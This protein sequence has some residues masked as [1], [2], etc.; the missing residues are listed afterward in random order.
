[1]AAGPLPSFDDLAVGFPAVV[2][3]PVGGYPTDHVANAHR[4]LSQRYQTLRRHA[5]RGPD[6]L[7]RLP[8]R[9]SH[10]PGAVRVR[11]DHRLAP[12]GR[13]R[14]SRCRRYLHR[15]PARQRPAA[16]PARR[17]HRLPELCPVSSHER[18]RK[19]RLRPQDERALPAGHRRAGRRGPF[20]ISSTWIPPCWTSPTTRTMPT[21]CP[22]SGAPPPSGSTPP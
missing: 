9:I 10:P 11:Q 13:F 20:H 7:R 16:Q 3:A 15:R 14:R 19:R 4:P 6:E 1:M 17:Q 2:S 22:T 8:G 5:G 21:A 12:H 18:D